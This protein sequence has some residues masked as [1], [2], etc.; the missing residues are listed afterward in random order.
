MA[1]NRLCG[2]DAEF[3]LI[4]ARQNAA[5]GADAIFDVPLSTSTLDS[6]N[7]A[8]WR[9]EFSGTRLA[10]ACSGRPGTGCTGVFRFARFIGGDSLGL[11]AG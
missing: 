3:R 8:R 11:L 10:K 4:A 7:D 5:A 2:L 9:K 6:M 1:Q